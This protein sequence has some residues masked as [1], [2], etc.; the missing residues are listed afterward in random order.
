MQ[1]QRRN[2]DTLPIVTVAQALQAAIEALNVLAEGVPAHRRETYRLDI[3]RI[4]Q[5]RTALL[6]WADERR[7][8]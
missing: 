1:A 5:A 8:Y 2:M 7:S 4:A 3:R 6:E